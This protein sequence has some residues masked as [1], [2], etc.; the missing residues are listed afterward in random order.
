MINSLCH[1]VSAFQS[2]PTSASPR[3]LSTHS[4]DVVVAHFQRIN[5]SAR[6]YPIPVNLFKMGS[7]SDV[8][9]VLVLLP[10]ASLTLSFPDSAALAACDFPFSAGGAPQGSSE[11]PSEV[12]T[13]F[14]WSS[15][16]KMASQSCWLEADVGP[17]AFALTWAKPLVPLE[18]IALEPM[19]A[20]TLLSLDFGT[21]LVMESVGGGE[22]MRV[23]LVRAGPS[24]AKVKSLVLLSAS[25]ASARSLNRQN[26]PSRSSSPRFSGFRRLV[27]PWW[28]CRFSYSSVGLTRQQILLPKASAGGSRWSAMLCE[29]YLMR[30][31]S[32]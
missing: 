10:L 32:S 19:S 17:V 23:E 30:C 16:E 22:S 20:K 11:P 5:A 21:L 28:S 12:S 15:P 31:P 3:M 1:F 7:S 24:K 4:V 14:E 25:W 13:V 6:G 18:S 8:F 29:P 9:A 26:R 27:C 2:P